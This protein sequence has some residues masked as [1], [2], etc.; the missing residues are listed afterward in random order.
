M[1]LLFPS[2]GTRNDVKLPHFVWHS[3]I[4]VDNFKR[5]SITNFSETSQSKKVE[6]LSYGN[7]TFLD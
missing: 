5:L 1:R 4:V 7:S 6:S 3:G 2:Y